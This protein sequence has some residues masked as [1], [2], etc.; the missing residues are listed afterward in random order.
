MHRDSEAQADRL[1][2][3]RLA[4]RRCAHRHRV[5]ERG[6]GTVSA[7]NGNVRCEPAKRSG[8]KNRRLNV[9]SRF[10]CMRAATRTNRRLR[11]ARRRRQRMT[12]VEHDLTAF[13]WTRLKLAWSGCAY[14]GA[15]GVQLQR[16]CVQPIGRGGRYTLQNV[17]PA[18]RSCNASK[19]DSE[20]SSWLRRKQ[21]DERTFLLRYS[22]I[23]QL[24]AQ[25]R[26]SPA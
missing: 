1:G 21:L 19:C 22:E 18:C 11:D 16:D 25:E 26:E 9:R 13:E 20:V 14:C 2:R 3:R 24:L 10:F 8:E 15:D 4:H 5:E 6:V 12:R 7:R 17:V 23:A